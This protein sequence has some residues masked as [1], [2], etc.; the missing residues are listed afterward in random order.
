MT[1][2]VKVL[3]ATLGF[4]ERKRI[5]GKNIVCQEKRERHKLRIVGGVVQAIIKLEARASLLLIQHIVKYRSA[6]A[7]H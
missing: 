7:I 6:I 5:K 4:G 3:D 2:T 1:R